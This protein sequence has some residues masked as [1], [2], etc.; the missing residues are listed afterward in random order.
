MI[1][2]GGTQF[3][4][5]SLGSRRSL[6]ITRGKPRTSMSQDGD[7]TPTSSRQTSSPTCFPLNLPGGGRLALLTNRFKAPLGSGLFRGAWSPWFRYDSHPYIHSN[8]T[9]LSSRL[10]LLLSTVRCMKDFQTGYS[11]L[12]FLFHQSTTGGPLHGEMLPQTDLFFTLH[13]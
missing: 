6:V 5:R 4:G 10:L 13:H 9:L 7:P 3:Q 11:F 1:D 12:Y 2:I 8:K